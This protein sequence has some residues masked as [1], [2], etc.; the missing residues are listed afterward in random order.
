MSLAA[1]LWVDDNT[2]SVVPTIAVGDKRMLTDRERVERVKWMDIDLK[3]KTP[4]DG[5]EVHNGRVL[6]LGGML[7]I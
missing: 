7:S 3:K 1:I 6:F 5:W 2:S 4:A